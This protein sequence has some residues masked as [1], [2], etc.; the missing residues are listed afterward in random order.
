MLIVIEGTDGAGKT[1]LAK[2]LVD[3][4]NS[5]DDF[6]QQAMYIRDPGSTKLGELLRPIV[7]GQTGDLILDNFAEALLFMA[8]RQQ[9][10][11]EVIAPNNNKIIVCDRFALSTAIYQG[12]ARDDMQVMECVL[13]ASPKA[14][15][16]IV[17]TV[18]PET[19]LSRMDKNDKFTEDG[20]ETARRRT[21]FYSEEEFTKQ[22]ADK[23][24]TWDV[25]GKSKEEVLDMVFDQFKNNFV[26]NY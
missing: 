22:F 9:M 4:I 5:D 11:S 1:T 13:V 19:A 3:R 18:S 7:K 10:R 23:S 17:L 24:Y 25:D 20:L 15:I 6:V 14:D 16:Q 2:S 8:I 21:K 12:M 26:S